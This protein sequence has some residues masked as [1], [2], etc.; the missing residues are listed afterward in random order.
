MGAYDS[1]WPSGGLCPCMLG[2]AGEA[3]ALAVP[4]TK[5]LR[6]TATEAKTWLCKSMIEWSLVLNA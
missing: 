2:T 5:K 1:T 3:Q 6:E 4:A